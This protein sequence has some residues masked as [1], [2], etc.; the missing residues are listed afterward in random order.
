M[1]RIKL[2]PLSEYEFATEIT[3]RTTDLNYRGHLGNDRLIAL[4]HEA[5]AA[6]LAAHGFTEMDCG[7]VSLIIADAVVNYQ[8]EAFAGD[9][10][11]F[12][13]A[14]GDPTESGFRLFYRVTR[15]NDGADI[16]LVEN[17]MVCFDYEKRKRRP[18]PDAVRKFCLEHTE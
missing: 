8:G 17:G 15:L 12:E 6:F 16:A 4:I 1:P 7:G 2:Q 14:A 18:L 11:R 13:A 10:L 3:V 5:R 9:V